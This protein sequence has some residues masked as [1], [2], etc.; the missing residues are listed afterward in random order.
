MDVKEITQK[1]FNELLNSNKNGK[2]V[3]LGLFYIKEDDGTYTGIDNS[4]GEAWIK[5][6]KTLE[7]CF[8]WLNMGELLNREFDR[9][10]R[11]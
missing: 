4:T 11:T 2:Y 3:P 6:F 5:N 9:K 8:N 1:E 7:K 10:K